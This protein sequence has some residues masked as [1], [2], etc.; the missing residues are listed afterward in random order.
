MY[1]DHRDLMKIVDGIAKLFE[2]KSF[3]DEWNNDS[4]NAEMVALK[5]VLDNVINESCRYVSDIIIINIKYTINYDL[6]HCVNN[7]Y[8]NL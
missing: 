7:N 8:I 4:P 5:F 6:P 1:N 3:L 2:E